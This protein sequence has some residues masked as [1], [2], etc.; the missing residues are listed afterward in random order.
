MVLPG[1]FLF[2][3]FFILFY[4]YCTDK[5]AVDTE[6]KSVTPWMSRGK[7]R[8]C[9]PAGNTLPTASQAA[10]GLLCHKGALWFREMANNAVLSYSGVSEVDGDQF[11]WN[12][13]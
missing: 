8:F 13:Y 3:F 11:C 9:Q 10:A 2:L 6:P 12:C 1:P 7:D 4:F 5:L